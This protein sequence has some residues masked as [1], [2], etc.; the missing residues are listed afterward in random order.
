MK[1]IRLEPLQPLKQLSRLE[2]LYRPLQCTKK[3]LSMIET[4]LY[5]A[6]LC[7][8][9]M[10]ILRDEIQVT[11]KYQKLNATQNEI[12]KLS[13]LIQKDNYEFHELNTYTKSSTKKFFKKV[14]LKPRHIE[15]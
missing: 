2:P 15:H 1:S 11:D 9:T 7:L 5:S 3:N 6:N 4:I 8:F 12:I 10:R 13:R 14:G